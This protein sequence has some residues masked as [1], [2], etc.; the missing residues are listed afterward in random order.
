MKLTLVHIFFIMLLLL[1]GLGVGLGLGLQMAAAVL[2]ESDQLLNEFQ[3]SDS[4]DK[5]EATR[6][7]ASTRSVETLPLSHKEVVQL[8]ETIVSED[9]VGGNKMLRAE[10]LFQSNKDYLRS[11]LMDRECNTLMAQKMKPHN[12]TCIPRYIFI[13]EELDA[14]KAVCKS[15]AIACDLKGGKCHKS[16]RPFDLTFCK[17]SKPGQVTPHCNYITFIL[18]KYIFISC[19]DMKVQVTS[20]P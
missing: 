3:S 15:P 18:E 12:H 1:L 2:E 20:G 19:S 14:V 10:A 8:E 7:G 17:L 16:S 6:E 4:Q 5:A 11:D 9:E 13:H